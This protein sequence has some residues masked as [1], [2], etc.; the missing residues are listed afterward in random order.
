M[1]EGMLLME[2]GDQ[3]EIDVNV[4]LRKKKEGIV[5]RSV[6]YCQ[7]KQTNKEEFR[8]R[9]LNPGLVGESHIS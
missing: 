3:E 2:R 5:L 6:C 1:T 8:I 9:E 7:A 4:K